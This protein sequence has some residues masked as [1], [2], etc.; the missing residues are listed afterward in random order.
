MR[1]SGARGTDLP[2]HAREMRARA[3][4]SSEEVANAISHGVGLLAS[5]AA[6]PVLIMVAMRRGDGL[7]AIGAA[8]FGV[9]LL[10][11][12][13]TSTIYHAL[14]P[15][16]AKESWR[17][18]DHAAIYLLIAGT[19]TPFLVGALR[20]PW[21]WSLAPIIWTL[22]LAGIVLKLRYGAS[23]FAWLSTAAYL[24]MGWMALV[25]VGPLLGRLGWAGLGWLLAGGLAYTLGVI[26]FTCDRRIRF[27]HC[28]WHFCVL[29]GSACHAVAVLAYGVT[30]PR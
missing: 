28:M 2:I 27:G 9:S 3:G 13:S 23:R 12:Y 30:P 25:A 7:T 4:Q 16:P 1:P 26:F 18:L 6:L 20:G 24:G 21:G 8:V 14:P 15:G 19:Y 29:G 11:V 5:V 10:C 22:A 17:R